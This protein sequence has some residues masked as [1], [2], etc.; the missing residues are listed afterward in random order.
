MCSVSLAPASSCAGSQ[1]A[2]VPA[3]RASRRLP[4][5]SAG[6]FGMRPGTLTDDPIFAKAAQVLNGFLKSTAESAKR[7][8]VYCPIPKAAFRS[9]GILHRPFGLV[10]SE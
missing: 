4:S 1:D 6:K 5:R 8:C 9:A 10:R 7:G 3:T 2:F